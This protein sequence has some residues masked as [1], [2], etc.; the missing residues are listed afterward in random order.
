MTQVDVHTE[1]W[2]ALPEQKWI[3][4]QELRDAIRGVTVGCVTFTAEADDIIDF[5]IGGLVDQEFLTWRSEYKTEP[6]S[7]SAW[8]KLQNAMGVR[9]NMPPERR[10]VL[11][12]YQRR[13]ASDVPLVESRRRAVAEIRD[14]AAKQAEQAD[15]Q[16]LVT[17]K[18]LGFTRDTTSTTTA[19]TTEGA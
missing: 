18:R 9:T 8:Q 19:S 3:T 15:A 1:L 14:A 12:W 4:H 2:R 5:W 7:A 13:P 6:M 11:F 10:Y 16:F 17:A